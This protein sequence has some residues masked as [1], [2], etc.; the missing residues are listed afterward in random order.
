MLTLRR[1]FAK[2]LTTQAFAK[3]LSPDRSSA[4]L[5]V[6]PKLGA[7][8]QLLA[9]RLQQ[10]QCSCKSAQQTSRCLCSQ[11]S[12]GNSSVTVSN[13]N[14]V[15][16]CD[17][18]L[19][20]AGSQLFDATLMTSFQLPPVACVLRRRISTSSS[21]NIAYYCQ[22]ARFKQAQACKT[23]ERAAWCG[24]LRTTAL[25][26]SCGFLTPALRLQPASKIMMSESG[27]R[28]TQKVKALTGCLVTKTYD[29][30]TNM[31]GIQ[32]DLAES[33]FNQR[34]YTN[35]FCGAIYF[36]FCH[37]SKSQ[38]GET[39]IKVLWTCEMTR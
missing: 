23:A 8:A 31:L 12:I 37:C 39:G 20:S 26:S 13:I 14:L 9:I 27:C 3:K 5:F 10:V 32:K 25:E 18:A 7:R 16:S 30:S 34:V 29:Q 36:D 38:A 21:S 33:L 2:W 28:G 35:I 22:H 15:T 1:N 24:Q 11:R 17:C 19:L 4:Q 6:V